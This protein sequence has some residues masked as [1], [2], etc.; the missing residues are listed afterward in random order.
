M[1]GPK[2]KILGKIV[3]RN[4]L[5]GILGVSAMTIG[6]YVAMGMPQIEAG[7]QGRPA[8]YNELACRNWVAERKSE[9]SQPSG[10]EGKRRFSLAA[11]ELK[12][13]QLAERRG[14]MISV[15]QVAPI[16]ADELAVVR[17][18]LLAIPERL[19]PALGSLTEAVRDEILGALSE[20]TC[21]KSPPEVA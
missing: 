19:R 3:N 1:A 6:R 8:K 11:A 15:E 18:R 2:P 9:E 13:L 17:S 5:T 12:E 21:D 16:L 10:D 20:L 14:T 7:S 4:E